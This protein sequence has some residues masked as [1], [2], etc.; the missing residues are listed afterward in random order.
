[1]LKLKTTICFPRA[2]RFPGSSYFTGGLHSIE[3]HLFPSVLYI[4]IYWTGICW[5]YVKMK[6]EYATIFRIMLESVRIWL[7]C[8][9]WAGVCCVLPLIPHGF[10]NCTFQ[11]IIV[12]VSVDRKVLKRTLVRACYHFLCNVS[13]LVFL[14][15]SWISFWYGNWVM[16][17][18]SPAHRLGTVLGSELPNRIPQVD[19]LSVSKCVR[20]LVIAELLCTAWLG[21]GLAQS[22]RNNSMYCLRFVE[23]VGLSGQN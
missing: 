20:A 10:W 4:C 22:H 1:M 6:Y 7:D 8:V 2:E 12:D 11:C 15:C 18:V 21:W 19:F 3:S 14:H 17:I 16:Y 13:L 23:A 9:C 5:K